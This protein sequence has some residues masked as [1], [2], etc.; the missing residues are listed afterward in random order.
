MSSSVFF[1]K[2]RLSVLK[3]AS[4]RQKYGKRIL[5]VWE[6]SM[7]STVVSAGPVHRTAAAFTIFRGVG[8][9]GI[10]LG[11]VCTSLPVYLG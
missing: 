5:D 8:C 4:F 7:I 1:V 6:S 3:R 10:F 9:A 11:H 2:S